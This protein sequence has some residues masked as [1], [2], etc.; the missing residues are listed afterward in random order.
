MTKS[1][2]SLKTAL[3]TK[4]TALVN[5]NSIALFAGVY[6][7]META[8]T[9]YPCAFVLERTGKGSILDTHRNEREWQFAV[10]IKQAIGNQTPE[11]AYAT[12]LEAADIVITSF[13]EDPMLLD[14]DSQPQCKWVR[15]VP[16]EFIYGNG[17]QAHHSAEM[18]VAIVDI[19]NR[20]A[21]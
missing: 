15:V 8:P 9:G 11:Q 16:A 3:I 1:Y 5:A 13:D 4:L 17:E 2:A 10:I 19:V 14:A 21:E 12:L 20:F 6:G 18:V 7:V